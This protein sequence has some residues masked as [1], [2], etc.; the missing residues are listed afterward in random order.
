MFLVK[1]KK[2]KFRKFE[3]FYCKI[4][5]LLKYIGKIGLFENK[6]MK[7]FEILINFYYKIKNWKNLILWD[8]YVIF[9]EVVII[10]L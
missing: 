10:M 7:L 4:N 3:S 6:K 2:I 8:C 5:K 9:Y 1:K